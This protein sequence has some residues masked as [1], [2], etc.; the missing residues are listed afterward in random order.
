MR[1]S[2]RSLATIGA[3][4][5][6]ALVSVIGISMGDSPAPPGNQSP[7]NPPATSNGNNLSGDPFWIERLD[8]RLDAIF[9]PAGTK[10]ETLGDRFALAEG[11]LWMP[12]GDK[13]KGDGYWLFSENAG[14]VIYKYKDGE[15]WSVFLD[16]SGYTGDSPTT[17]GFQTTMGHTAIILIGSNGLA[18]DPNENLVV[19]AMNDRLVYRL[20]DDGTRTVLADR[21]EGMRFN[22][23]NDIVVKSDGTIYFTDTIFGLRG[24]DDP[25]RELPFSGFYMIKDGEVTYLG[26][27]RDP[28][29][30]AANGITLSPDEKYLYVTAGGRTMRYEIQ[31]DDT[32]ANG[33]EFVRH[34]NDGLRVDSLGNLYSSSGGVP[35]VIQITAPDG[36]PIGRIHLPNPK[37]EPAPRVCATN[38]AFGGKNNQ[39]MFI[40]AC[41]HV[42]RLHINV[43]GIRPG[44]LNNG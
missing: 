44:Q 6:V 19:T 37:Y 34:G 32:I 39:D 38:L 23:P 41:T 30:R 20:E 27:D 42:F 17:T 1:L 15:P 16:K 12:E 28:G 21:F 33:I 3:T 10:I 40:T 43:P 25:T 26:G 13:A 7:N 9:K 22:G 14:N 4:A 18:L 36:T 35:G 24:A 2:G 5:A 29:G 31:A 8:P 11:A